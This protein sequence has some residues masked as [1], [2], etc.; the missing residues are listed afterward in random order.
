MERRT[1]GK[2]SAIKTAGIGRRIT[3]HLNLTRSLAEVWGISYSDIAEV[4]KELNGS[5]TSASKPAL[6][7]VAIPVMGGA[8]VKR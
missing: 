5:S 2:V 7:N 6:P 4:R 8:G 1:E 3:T